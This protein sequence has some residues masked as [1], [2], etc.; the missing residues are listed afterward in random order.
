LLVFI[1][2]VYHDARSQDCEKCIKVLRKILKKLKPD[3]VAAENRDGYAF[4]IQWHLG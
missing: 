3:S 1:K 2:Q 4:R